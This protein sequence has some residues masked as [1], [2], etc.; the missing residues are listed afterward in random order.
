[1]KAEG[2]DITNQQQLDNLLVICGNEFHMV[3]SQAIEPWWSAPL[4]YLLYE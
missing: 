1:M 3:W 4:L 2:S